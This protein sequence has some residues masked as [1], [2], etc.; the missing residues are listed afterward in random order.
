MNESQLR[1]KKQLI[2]I[3]S[4]SLLIHMKSFIKKKIWHLIAQTINQPTKSEPRMYTWEKEL[5]YYL[6]SVPRSVTREI[7]IR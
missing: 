1:L 3:I 2:K 6:V 5:D 7:H 4:N